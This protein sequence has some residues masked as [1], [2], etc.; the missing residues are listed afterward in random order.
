[1]SLRSV[2]GSLA[3]SEPLPLLGQIG[4]RCERTGLRKQVTTDVNGTKKEKDL[5]WIIIMS[6]FINVGNS[7]EALK[8]TRGNGKVQE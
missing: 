2:K 3:S 7:L 6:L 4:E 1:M 5:G 8:G